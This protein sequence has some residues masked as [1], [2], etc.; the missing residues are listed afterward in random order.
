VA[1][2]PNGQTYTVQ[3]TL[4]S[5]ESYSGVGVR[6][7]NH[8]I[9]GWGPCVSVVAYTDVGGKLTGRW[10]QAGGNALG[11]ETLARK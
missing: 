6:E 9:V 1:I 3:W 8:F 11:S 4:T 5:G 7:G 10:A 2:T